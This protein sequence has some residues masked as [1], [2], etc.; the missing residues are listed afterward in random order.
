MRIAEDFMKASI[1]G[2]VLVV[3]SLLDQGVDINCRDQTK[4]TRTALMWA[5]HIGHLELARVLIAREAAVNAT[6]RRGETALMYACTQGRVECVRL[7]LEHGADSSMKSKGGE[8]AK[9][10]ARKKNSNVVL[11]ILNMVRDSFLFFLPFNV[12]A[13]QSL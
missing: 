2:D 3:Q 8:S 9:D 1:K 12:S 6:D 5:C 10:M 7:L 4:N 13:I 11:N